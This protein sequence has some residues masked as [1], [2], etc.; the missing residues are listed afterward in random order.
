M[1]MLVDH[2]GLGVELPVALGIAAILEGCPPLRQSGT[3]SP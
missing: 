3:S 1:R 2:A